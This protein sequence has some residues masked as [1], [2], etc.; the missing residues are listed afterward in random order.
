MGR[1]WLW[2]FPACVGAVGDRSSLIQAG[3]AR[4][5]TQ[6]ATGK[7]SISWALKD[8]NQVCNTYPDFDMVFKNPRQNG[9][10]FLRFQFGW[11]VM[12]ITTHMQCMGSVTHNLY[13]DWADNNRGN[14]S[15]Y[16]EALGKWKEVSIVEWRTQANNMEPKAW[17]KEGSSYEE[18]PTCTTF[19]KTLPT[20][21]EACIFRFYVA[22][23]DDCDVQMSY[24]PWID[25]PFP[26]SE[27]DPHITNVRGKRFDVFSTGTLTMV[28]V[29]RSAPT[30]GAA[31][32]M[33]ATLEQIPGN[34]KCFPT[35]IKDVRL[36]GHAVGESALT[37][38][39]GQGSPEVFVGDEAQYVHAL[40]QVLA[41]RADGSLLVK[42]GAVSAVISQRASRSQGYTFL[43]VEVHGLETYGEDAGGLLGLDGYTGAS[44]PEAGCRA[45]H[46]SR[47]V[48][49][50]SFS[51][52]SAA[53][54]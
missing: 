5:E 9:L 18:V 51:T 21:G 33:N 24:A 28:K 26:G 6:T 17:F 49:S 47:A 54:A 14:L 20:D 19:E 52:A 48:E 40:P 13:L 1:G 7:L 53:R 22:D 36:Q 2:M 10:N 23:S 38:R 43:N 44:E 37:I 46:L 45:V 42:A 41:R 32:I 25:G 15:K 27:G 39:C 11:S 29:P 3:L 34:G 12:S 8:P 35:V 31:L 50:Y 4:E 16:D 30:S